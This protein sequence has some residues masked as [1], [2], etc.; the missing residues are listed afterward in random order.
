MGQGMITRLLTSAAGFRRGR[1]PVTSKPGSFLRTRYADDE[2][3]VMAQED[4]EAALLGPPGEPGIRVLHG[5][6]AVR[7]SSATGALGI[8][9]YLDGKRLGRIREAHGRALQSFRTGKTEAFRALTAVIRHHA[10]LEEL[11]NR[12]ADQELDPPVPRWA[13]TVFLA[14]LGFGD[15]T[16]TSVSF[17]VLNI[18]DRPLAAWLPFSPL[19]VAAI[20]VVGGMLGAAHFLG[21]SIRAHR[22]EPGQRQVIIGA[23]SL[24]GGLCLTLAIAAIRS[25]FLAVNGVMTLSFPFIGIQVGLFAVATAASAWAAHPFHAQWKKH[26]RTLRRAVRYYQAKRRRAGRR[27]GLVNGYA[28]RHLSLVCQ[29]ASSAQAVLSDGTRQRYLYR[30]GY[31]LAGS[32]E[33]A[34]AGLWSD[35]AGPALPPEVLDLLDYPDR[36][37]PGSNIEPLESVNLDDL[38]ADWEKLQRQL[39]HEAEATRQARDD[40]GMTLAS[41]RAAYGPEDRARE[42]ST[43]RRNGTLLAAAKRDGNPGSG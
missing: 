41:T 40:R 23:A 2:V 25:A 10:R 36:I 15:L 30:R 38:D 3:E 28:A 20:P 34:A 24:A 9:N 4:G 22:H 31:L 8:R 1:W 32:P 33:P 11:R 37:R 27:A 26:T 29:A 35:V 43:K 7:E 19:N 17:M 13:G 39:R 42:E 18:S 12:L 6:Q 16:M 14:A 21:E 5:E